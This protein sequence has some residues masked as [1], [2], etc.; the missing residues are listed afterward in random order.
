[1]F[2]RLTTRVRGPGSLIS[3]APKFGVAVEEVAGMSR[4][5]KAD[6]GSFVFVFR[7]VVLLDLVFANHSA[8]E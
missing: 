2:Y 1:M 6:R 5:M 4:G 7:V 3:V 8:L